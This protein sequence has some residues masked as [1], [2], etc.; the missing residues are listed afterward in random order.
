[1][2]QA[3]LYF[4]RVCRKNS[5]KNPFRMIT[6][7]VVRAGKVKNIEGIEELIKLYQ[8]HINSTKEYIYM[9]AWEL[10]SQKARFIYCLNPFIVIQA[11]I[12]QKHY[13]NELPN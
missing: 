3:W 4:G 1:V 2:G 9:A 11:I 6:E 12:T 5:Y 8:Q 10:F 7:L 13:K